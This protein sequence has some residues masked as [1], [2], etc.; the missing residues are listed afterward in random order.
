MR[1]ISKR[2]RSSH[3]A[4]PLMKMKTPAA[5]RLLLVASSSFLLLAA[6]VSDNCSDVRYTSYVNKW[7]A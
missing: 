4:A 1:F 2:S 5:G 6:A 3:G 7:I